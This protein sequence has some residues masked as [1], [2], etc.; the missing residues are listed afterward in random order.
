MSKPMFRQG[1]V[2]LVLETRQRI[3]F[4]EPNE[5]NER[6]ILAHGEKTGHSHSV[7]ALDARLREESSQGSVHRFLD[8]RRATTLC[9]EEHAPILLSSGTYRVILQRQY[10]PA[11]ERPVHD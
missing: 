2:L 1:D 9:H 10:D 6:V 11:T 8:V 7:A 3:M 5:A 4:D